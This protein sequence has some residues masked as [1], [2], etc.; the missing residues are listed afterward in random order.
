MTSLPLALAAAL[1]GYY[2]CGFAFQFGGLGLISPDPAF[3]QMVA[4]WSP[5]DLRLGPG[6][7]VVGLR[8]FA[9]VVI[10]SG[11]L[12]LS[13]FLAYFMLF[14]SWAILLMLTLM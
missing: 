10:F 7:G 5:L 12:I 2:V 9:L 8:G 6:W 4:E 13:L 14:S 11:G 1:I 3:S